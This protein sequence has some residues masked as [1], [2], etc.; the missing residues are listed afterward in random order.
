MLQTMILSIVVIPL[1]LGAVV[2]LA[3]NAAGGRRAAVIALLIPLFAAAALI[4]LDGWPA[5]PPVRAAHKFPYVLAIGGV[6]F[7]LAALVRRRRNAALTALVA[8]ISIALP[9]WWMGRTI[10]ANN[11]QKATV[12]AIIA[13]LAVAGAFWQAARQ[14]SAAPE[15]HVLP[16]AFFATS[17]AAALVAIFG[18]YMGMAM[19]NGALAA[20]SGGFLL[21]TYIRYLRGEATAF[22][23]PGGAALAFGWVALMGVAVTALSAPKASAAALVTTTLTLVLT[24]LSNLYGPRLISLP[25][26]ARPLAN[27]LIAALP[28]LAG[29]AIAAL[30]FAG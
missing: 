21:V 5:F 28:A 8:L 17:I 15:T 18:G 6:L 13:V 29:I 20:L 16:Q 9:L 30:Q 10:L 12:L 27:G 4:G 11:P 1:V 2:A 19:F 24:P 7:G 14:P 23:L 25:Y 22:A 3:A 26:A